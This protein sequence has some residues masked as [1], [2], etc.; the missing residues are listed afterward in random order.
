MAIA[1]TSNST[2]V[3]DG[4]R[5][6]YPEATA[7]LA[8]GVPGRSNAR[9]KAPRAPKFKEETEGRRAPLPFRMGIKTARPGEE[10]P[11]FLSSRGDPPL[12]GNATIIQ[13][14]GDPPLRGNATIIQSRGDILSRP[15]LPTPGRDDMACPEGRIFCGTKWMNN[16]NTKYKARACAVDG[17]EC[18]TSQRKFHRMRSLADVS[19][20]KLLVLSNCIHGGT[21]E[22]CNWST[23]P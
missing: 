20:D 4:H 9:G 2:R 16:G 23:P 11:T 17:V 19:D 8:G 15:P 3:E 13:S 21:G 12:R 22:K 10:E 7:A 18:H 5:P 1:D 6:Y 14:R